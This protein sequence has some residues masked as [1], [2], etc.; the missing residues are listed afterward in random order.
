MKSFFEPLRT[1]CD[2]ARAGQTSI[3]MPAASGRGGLFGRLG[4]HLGVSRRPAALE[5]RADRPRSAVRSASRAPE[6]EDPRHAWDQLF[7]LA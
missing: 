7:I 2:I 1:V 3:S 6:I 5:P 4:G